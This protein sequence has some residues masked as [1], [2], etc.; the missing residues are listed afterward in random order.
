MPLGEMGKSRRQKSRSLELQGMF[1][2]GF[3]LEP[4]AFKLPP[5]ESIILALAHGG[6]RTC[7]AMHELLVFK[8]RKK[9]RKGCMRLLQVESRLEPARPK[10]PHP[11]SV[12]NNGVVMLIIMEVI[13][14]LSHP[15]SLGS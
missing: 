4:Y 7:G 2:S 6:R 9:E 13:V 1:L 12:F 5:Q 15:Y 11:Y 14:F 10:L 3:A 8:E